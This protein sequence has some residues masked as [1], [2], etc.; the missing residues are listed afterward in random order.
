MIDVN[1]A[2][3]HAL[4]ARSDVLQSKNS[5]Q[6]N[7]IGIRYLRNQA[8]PEVNAVANYGLVGVG[9]SQLRR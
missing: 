1:G 7:D 5:L 4:S 9:G 6:Q 3:N 2:V 8:M